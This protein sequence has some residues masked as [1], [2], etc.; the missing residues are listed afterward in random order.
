MILKRVCFLIIHNGNIMNFVL[1]LKRA[2]T[3]VLIVKNIEKNYSLAHV[4]K[5]IVTNSRIRR[6]NVRLHWCTTLPVKRPSQ[7]ILHDCEC[8]TVL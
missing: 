8:K 1:K 4:F 6:R 5:I 7:Q 3:K 2:K